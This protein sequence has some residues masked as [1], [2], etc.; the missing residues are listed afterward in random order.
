MQEETLDRTGAGQD[1]RRQFALEGGGGGMGRRSPG[2]G[3]APAAG[4]EGEAGPVRG[5]WTG[6]GESGRETEETESLKVKEQ[7]SK[8][9]GA[10]LGGGSSLPFW[11]LKAGCAE[12]G[13]RALGGGGAASPVCSPGGPEAG[14]AGGSLL[15]FED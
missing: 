2:P 5:G 13:L 1:S 8:H 4:A 9:M 7:S 15:S 12:S 10:G 6:R 14:G 11:Q 3:S